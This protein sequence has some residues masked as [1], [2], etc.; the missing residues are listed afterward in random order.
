ME[1]DNYCSGVFSS[2]PMVI[3]EIGKRID[4]IQPNRVSHREFEKIISEECN[5]YITSY[6]DDYFEFNEGQI[7]VSVR[8]QEKKDGSE[9]IYVNIASNNNGLEV[10]PRILK[11]YQCKFRLLFGL[12]EQDIMKKSEAYRLYC[13][14]LVSN[15]LGYNNND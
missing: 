7:T 14:A 12:T 13:I 11:K 6:F 10:L 9:T 4:S 3:Q 5:I 2:D 8:Y 15:I 1:D